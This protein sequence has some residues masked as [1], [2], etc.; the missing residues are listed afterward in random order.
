MMREFNCWNSDQ[1]EI[2][3]SWTEVYFPAS[4]IAKMVKSI[5]ALISTNL[6]ASR[7]CLTVSQVS[8]QLQIGAL[9]LLIGNN[10]S[11]DLNHILLSFQVTTTRPQIQNIFRWPGCFLRNHS[12]WEHH[13]SNFVENVTNFWNFL[14]CPKLHVASSKIF[15]YTVIG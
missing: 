4:C 2:W 6:S 5:S 7:R 10:Q 12:R 3:I 13:S 15:A 9:H 8:T 1:R 14:P 11:T